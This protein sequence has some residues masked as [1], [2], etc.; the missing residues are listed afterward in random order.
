MKNFTG[1]TSIITG[2]SSGIGRACA[3]EL[4][5]Q[6]SNLVLCARDVSKLYPV[7]AECDALGVKAFAIRADVSVEEDCRALIQTAI[8]QFGSI[9]ILINNAGMSMRATFEQTD[10]S[11]LKKL[12]DINFWGAVYCTK[13]ALPWLLKSKGSVVGISSIAGF[14]GLPGRTGYSASKF[15]LN[16]FLET[17]R[18]ETRR[19]G[20]HVLICAPGFTASNIRNTAL[21]SAGQ[22][23]KESP[24]NESSLM[25]PEEV[26]RHILNAIRKRKPYLILTLLGKMTVLLNK[27]FPL[28]MDKM[29]YNRMANEENSPLKD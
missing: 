28:F 17:L 25:Q 4:A 22:A 10:L 23:Q 14:K 12:M 3:I 20:L 16:G 8:E 7:V 19:K 26:A 5:R 9:D 11:V 1:K 15:A 18:I 24:L 27:F 13:L 29:T 21:N 2:A 6:G